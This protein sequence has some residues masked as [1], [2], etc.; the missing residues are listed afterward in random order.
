MIVYIYIYILFHFSDLMCE[1]IDSKRIPM[2]QGG[3]EFESVS[4]LFHETIP[5]WKASILIVEKI[6]NGFLRERYNR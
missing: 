6:T 4:K 5:E 1:D 3:E 2:P